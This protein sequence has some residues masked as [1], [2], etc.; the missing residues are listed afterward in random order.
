M[1]LFCVTECVEDGSPV[2]VE[3]GGKAAGRRRARGGFLREREGK[4]RGGG[5]GRE[6]WRAVSSADG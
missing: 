5:R 3:G 6:G 1:V 2:V 4:Y